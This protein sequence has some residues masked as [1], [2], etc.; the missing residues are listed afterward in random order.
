MSLTV[1]YDTN[2]SYKSMSLQY[3]TSTSYG[4]TST[5][6]QIS[7]LNPNTTYYYSITVTD[8]WN[9]TSS[10]STGSFKTSAYLPSNL[11]ISVKSVSPFTIN[12]AISGAGDTNAPITYYTCHYTKKPNINTYDMPIKSFDGARWARIFYHNNKKGTVLFNSLAECKNIQT[13]DK[14]SRLGLL[15]NGDTYKINGKY[16]F[17]L[18]YPVDSGSKYNRWKQTNA[19]QND[20]IAQTTEGTGAATG[21]EAIHIDWNTNY[22]GGLTRQSSDT[23]SY[24]PTWLSGSVDH[25]N[26]FW[27]VGASSSYKRGIPSGTGITAIN[28]TQTGSTADVVELWIRIPDGDVISK[29]TSEITGLE[30]ETTYLL[31]V[32]ATNAAGTNYSSTVE[33]TTPADQAKIRI[34]QE[35]EWKKGKTYYKKDG[36]WVKAKKIYIKVD[37]QWKIGTNYDD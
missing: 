37:G 6:G 32:S 15:D 26:W 8:N 17:M 19:P 18:I 10:A 9:R 20:Y 11:S 36:A 30:E 16:E 14:Y 35:G 24:S 34:K 3:G 4:S 28:S 29:N 5:T 27:A 12:T 7:G 33:V 1:T 23:S 2:A 25:E 13:S 21:Y 31:N 22:W